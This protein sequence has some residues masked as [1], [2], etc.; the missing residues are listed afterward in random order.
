MA[1]TKTRIM[2]IEQQG[3][4]SAPAGRVGRVTLSKSGRTLY[5]RGH[6]FGSLNGR[7]YKTTHFDEESLEEYWISG[8]RNDGHDTLYPGVVEVDEDVREEYWTLIR[9]QPENAHL[10]SYRSPGKRA[11]RARR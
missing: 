5:Y 6:S 4:G 11:K 8:P 2:Y 3:G 7:G 10:K 9:K 1:A